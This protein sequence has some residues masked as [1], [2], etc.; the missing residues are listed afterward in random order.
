M[1]E[2]LEKLTVAHFFYVLGAGAA[3][4]FLFVLLEGFV[5][6][7]VESTLGIGRFGPVI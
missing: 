6:G 1:T 4:G 3:A 5:F 2:A 7:P